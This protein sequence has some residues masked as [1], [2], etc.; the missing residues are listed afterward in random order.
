MKMRRVRK[1][2]VRKPRKIITILCEGQK[3][4]P[5][6][7]QGIFNSKPANREGYVLRVSKPRDNS[8]RGIVR[9]AKEEKLAAIRDKISTEDFFI[10][11]VFDRNGHDGI[12]DAFDMADANDIKITFSSICFEFWILLHYFRTSRPFSDC[13]QL[14]HFIKEKYD[15]DYE[16]RNNHYEHLKARI[17]NAIKNGKWL[18]KEVQN[19]I[20]SGLKKVY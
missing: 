17:N 1:S 15:S 4:E 5:L 18:L 9:S 10:W 8:P 20:D 11:A 19:D 16:K 3:T 12:P 6:Y 7:F 14:I 13:D 2:A